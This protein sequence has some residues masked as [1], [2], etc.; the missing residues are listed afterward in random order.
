MPLPPKR[1]E[2][3]RPE[4]LGTI[5]LGGYLVVQSPDPGTRD[6]AIDWLL[7]IQ[8]AVAT[9][10]EA[11]RAVQSY[12]RARQ[13]C[14]NIQRQLQTLNLQGGLPPGSRCDHCP[15]EAATR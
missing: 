7:E 14:L 5:Q 15:A 1:K 10:P 4:G 6:Q 13:S 11:V 2:E 3:F 8:D 12:T 9:W